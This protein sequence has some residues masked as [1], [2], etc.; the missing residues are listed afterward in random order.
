VP[1]GRR[2]VESYFLN[3]GSTEAIVPVVI[4]AAGGH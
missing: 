1:A 2:L 3:L 4:E